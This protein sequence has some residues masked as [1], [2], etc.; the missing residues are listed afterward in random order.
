[1]ILVAG[2][3]STVGQELIKRLTRLGLPVRVLVRNSK[4]LQIHYAWNWH[5]TEIGVA[6]IESAGV[7]TGIYD[8]WQQNKS[9]YFVREEPIEPEDVA[10]AIRFILEQPAHVRIPKLAVFPAAH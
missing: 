4:T 2:A 3:T 10:R 9:D 8:G 5:R 6:C 7:T 1:M